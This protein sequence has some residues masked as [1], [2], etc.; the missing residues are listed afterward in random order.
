MQIETYEHTGSVRPAEGTVDRLDLPA[1]QWV[2]SDGRRLRIDQMHRR[3]LE[4]T[5]AKLRGQGAGDTA[6]YREM[7]AEL[8]ARGPEPAGGDGAVAERSKGIDLVPPFLVK[9]VADAVRLA[10]DLAYTAESVQSEIDEA[11]ADDV[12]GGEHDRRA[13]HLADALRA[14]LLTLVAPSRERRTIGVV[15]ATEITAGTIADALETWDGNP[16]AVS[17]WLRDRLEQEIFEALGLADDGADAG[18]DR[19]T[20]A[21]LSD[22][23]L[24]SERGY[25][26]DL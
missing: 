10:L 22:T 1:G 5:I 13:E 8:D 24:A 21:D 26:G 3:H 12:D 15:L 2:T 9:S 7:V 17:N 25:T 14:Q 18:A 23:D 6:K 20:V 4:N 19:F 16:K 11:Y